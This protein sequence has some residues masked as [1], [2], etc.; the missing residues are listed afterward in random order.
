M[1][2]V[3]IISRIVPVS[4]PALAPWL[5]PQVAVAVIGPVPSRHSRCLYLIVTTASQEANF[6]AASRIELKSEKAASFAELRHE[7]NPLKESSSHAY[8]PNSTRFMHARRDI[9]L[10]LFVFRFFKRHATNLACSPAK[11]TNPNLHS[12]RSFCERSARESLLRK[13]FSCWKAVSYDLR[14]H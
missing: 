14:R 8:G 1:R 3:V 12:A 11:M 4:R 13:E 2:S 6:L 10:P 5:S 7:S 9:P